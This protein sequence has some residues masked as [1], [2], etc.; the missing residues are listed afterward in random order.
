[1]FKNNDFDLDL[2]IKSNG[3]TEESGISS[4]SLCTPGCATNTCSCTCTC[5][6]H[7]FTSG[8]HF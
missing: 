6:C 4:Q 8:C 1:M 2:Q 3:N 5:G 7:Q